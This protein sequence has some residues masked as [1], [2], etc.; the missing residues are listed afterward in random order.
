MDGS[1]ADLTVAELCMLC[2]VHLIFLGDNNFGVL[3]CRQRIQS[4]I[5]ATDTQDE[6]DTTKQDQII[7][8]MDTAVA[9]TSL[10]TVVGILSDDLNTGTVVT[11]PSSP[12][13][14]EIE[15]AKCLLA[16]KREKNT[17]IM[18]PETTSNKTT[19]S[20]ATQPTTDDTNTGALSSNQASNKEMVKNETELNNVTLNTNNIP[21]YVETDA[22]ETNKTMT[23]AN[24]TTSTAASTNSETPGGVVIL[25]LPTCPVTPKNIHP[26]KKT[27]ETTEAPNPNELE[28]LNDKNSQNK[29]LVQLEKS[30]KQKLP[31]KRCSVLLDRLSATKV[32]K[33]CK[34][35]IPSTDIENPDP[36][37][38][39][40]TRYRTR[41]SL[42]PKH[43]RQGRLPRSVSTNVSYEISGASSE[44]D[45]SPAP[46]R[47]NKIRPKREPSSSRIKADNFVTKPPPV[48]PL[49][50]STRNTGPRPTNAMNATIVQ[51]QSTP[52]TP[53]LQ[54]ITKTWLLLPQAIQPLI[55]RATSK[56][57]ATD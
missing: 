14:S 32:K 4:P 37:T 11:L 2:D 35:K 51:N 46:K 10:G 38:P 24:V 57:K 31:M 20:I 19:G 47:H 52:A 3:K 54:Q 8:K 50:R 1:I 5:N 53:T 30:P 36:S 43:A 33:L 48:T 41:S 45:K 12:A 6:H 56:L 9:N 29:P 7:A 34:Q 25:P 44:E 17:A 49:R 28:T 26:E 55:P 22:V 18:P 39:V 15:A 23:T 42:K 27:V 40:E 16:L 21:Q 13:A